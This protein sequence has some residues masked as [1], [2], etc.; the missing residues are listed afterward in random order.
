MH[1][2]L[3]ELGWTDDQWNKI[4]SAAVEEAQRGRVAAQIL[5][6]VGPEDP[7]TVAIPEYGL[8]NVPSP[9]TNPP[10][11]ANRRLNVNSDPT[12]YLTTIA[13]NVSVRLRE[14][15]DPDLEAA[16]V[17]F[18]RAGNYI[19]RIE[20]ALVFNGRPGP[21]LPPPVGIAGIPPVFT[22][23]GDGAIN[24]L[25][26]G[27]PVI[28][29][30]GIPGTLGNRV[31]TGIIQAINQLDARGQ[32]GPY[33]CALSPFLF[34]AV[35]TPNGNLVLPR[36]RI[37]PFLQAPPFRSSA[38]LQFAPVLAWGVVVAGSGNP[39]EIVVA[40]D[41]H[42]RYL[43]TSEEPRLIFRVSERVALRIK[44]PQAI[45]ALRW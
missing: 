33:S 24:G 39:L 38:I 35:C 14:A 8:N 30:G 3:V 2:D 1:S 36:D 45:V 17:M 5:P 13:V 15:A 25:L 22:I 4:E 23:R 7:T 27:A 19:A 32:L 16:L 40:R 28:N 41:L 21:N 34:E 29:L 11:T 43:Q 9:S 12:L 20:D 44:E 31:V 26:T 42:V 37:I 18:R 6:V 10:Q